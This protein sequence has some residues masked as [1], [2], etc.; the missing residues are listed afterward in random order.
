MSKASFKSHEQSKFHKSRAKQVS[1]V[2]SQA[3]F[4]SYEQKQV[5]KVK[6]K[7]KAKNKSGRG[8]RPR[9]LPKRGRCPLPDL[10]YFLVVRLL[11]VR[12]IEAVPKIWARHLNL[13]VT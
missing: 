6:S 5:S 8:Q 10:F 2:M 1:Q 3:S 11:V 12:P 9:W 13:R 4:K 7:S